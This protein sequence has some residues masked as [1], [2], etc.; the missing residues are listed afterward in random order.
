MSVRGYMKEKCVDLMARADFYKLTA[1][2]FQSMAKKIEEEADPQ[3]MVAC[4]NCMS[5][6]ML[7][8]LSKMAAAD[9]ISLKLSQI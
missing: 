7:F 2:M 1:E 6:K 5:R 9:A 3:D 4:L 8:W